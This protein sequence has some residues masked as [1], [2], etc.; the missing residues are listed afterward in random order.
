M[1]RTVAFAEVSRPAS[2]HTRKQP[3]K[4]RTTGVLQKAPRQARVTLHKL[5]FNMPFED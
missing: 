2:L 1:K 3:N 4:R 5:R